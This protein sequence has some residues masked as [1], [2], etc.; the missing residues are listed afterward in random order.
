MT[1]KTEANDYVHENL[2]PDQTT[3]ARN[4][5]IMYFVAKFMEHILV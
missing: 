1:T 2:M 3:R 4:F 5:A